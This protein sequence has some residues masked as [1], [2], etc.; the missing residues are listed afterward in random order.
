MLTSL[1]DFKVSFLKVFFL[2]CR[3][4]EKDECKNFKNEE[5]NEKISPCFSYSCGFRELLMQVHPCTSSGNG[6]GG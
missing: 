4:A 2:I 1:L 3:E 6:P 5:I